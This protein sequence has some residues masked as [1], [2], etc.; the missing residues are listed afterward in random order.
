MSDSKEDK[1]SK[2][3]LAG[4]RIKLGLALGVM[5]CLNLY[6]VF[7]MGWFSL[8]MS[9]LVLFLVKYLWGIVSFVIGM[10]FVVVSS[11]SFIQGFHPS[12]YDD[13]DELYE[14]FVLPRV[15]VFMLF[16]LPLWYFVVPINIIFVFLGFWI[17]LNLFVAY[18]SLDYLGEDVII[19]FLFSLIIILPMVVGTIVNN[20]LSSLGREGDE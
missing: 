12:D 7:M 6:V 11:V 5:V 3:K 14:A 20:Y 9:H 17:I 18:Y 4:K 19:Y 10:G 16:L 15:F 13:E 8:V 2:G 1:S